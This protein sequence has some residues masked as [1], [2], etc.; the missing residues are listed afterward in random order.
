[1]RKKDQSNLLKVGV[2]ISFL[3]LVMMIMVVS[4]GKENSI[5]DSKVEI[6]AMVAN[7]SNLK[8]GS[9]VELKGIRIGA[10]KRI[11]IASEEEVEVTMTILEEQLRWIKNDSKVSISTAGLVGDKFIEIYGGYKTSPVLNPAKDILISENVTDLKKIMTKGESIASMAERILTK[12]DTILY[13]LD[14]GKKIVSSVDSLH[15]TIANLEKLSLE[16]REAKMGRMVGNVNATMAQL[17]KASHSMEK[18]M[19]RIE[20]GPGTMNSMIYDDSLHEDLR[21]LLGGAQRNKVIKYFIRESIKNSE[22]K[23]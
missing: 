6:R 21:A 22:K 13:N 19:T 4:I 9:Y 20:H 7:V 5:F 10:V 8:V 3:T 2:F 11:M 17:N 1:M 15:K 23:N 12:I 14:D 18:I 16:L